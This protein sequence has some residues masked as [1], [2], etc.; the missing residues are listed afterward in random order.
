MNTILGCKMDTTFGSARLV[1][2]V[3]CWCLFDFVDS[4]CSV[5]C[6]I[7][8]ERNLWRRIVKAYLC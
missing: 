6:M 3:G 4:L 2:V 7:D 5:S 8:H 1:V